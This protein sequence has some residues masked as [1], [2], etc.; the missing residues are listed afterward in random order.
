LFQP[1]RPA[2]DHDVN[3]TSADHDDRSSADNVNHTSADH[4]DRSSTDD[5]PQ[6]DDRPDGDDGPKGHDW[7]YCPL[8]H[9]ERAIAF[10]S[11]ATTPQRQPS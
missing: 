7:R 11:E 9:H 1:V 5:G 3:H 2:E 4:D 10:R 6:G 8:V